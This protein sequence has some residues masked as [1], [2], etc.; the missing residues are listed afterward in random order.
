MNGTN[1]NGHSKKVVVVFG[2]TGKQG[3]SVVRSIL[4]DPKTA[5]QF[6]IRAITR[7]PSKPAAQEL[8]KLGCECVP[9]DADDKD[10]L[11]RALEGAYAVF[12]VTNFWEKKSAE[13]EI[14]QGKNMADVAKE[15]GVQHYICSSLM[16]V[17]KL[18]GGKLSKVA[19]FDSKA[20]VEDYVRAI[21]LPATFFMPGFYMSNIPG[22]SLNNM[23]GPYS[24]ALPIP[25]DSP[26]PLFDTEHDTGKFVKAILLNREKVLGQRIYGATDYYTPEQIIADFQ[27]VKTKDG[28]GGAAKQVPE[29][30]FKKILAGKGLP[31]PFQDEML[32][33]MLLMPQF[34]YY[35]GAD[36]KASHSILN[37]PL[38]TWKEYVAKTPV[39]ADV[40]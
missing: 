15:V 27:A 13:A 14:Q 17:T 11:R 37:E 2:A 22:Q 8:T 10:S 16:N 5:S 39:W 33:N 24:F 40:H 19:H 3:G 26:I 38:T 29:P 25:T 36:L 30:A 7:D 32:E 6:S 23:Q 21:G 28:Q 9:A 4:G 34:G 20:E 18:S 1:T 12:A 35:G 31:E